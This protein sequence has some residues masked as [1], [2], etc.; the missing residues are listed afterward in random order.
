MKPIFLPRQARDKHEEHVKTERGK[1]RSFAG[2]L[3]PGLN[4]VIRELTLTLINVRTL[5][6]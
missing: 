5:H 4:N 3:C 2:G 6:T 1:G